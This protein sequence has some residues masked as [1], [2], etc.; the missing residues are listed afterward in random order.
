MCTLWSFCGNP[1]SP[2]SPPECWGYKHLPLCLPLHAGIFQAGYKSGFLLTV[3]IMLIDTWCRILNSGEHFCLHGYVSFSLSPRIHKCL[4][5]YYHILLVSLLLMVVAHPGPCKPWASAIVLRMPS[6]LAI[7]ESDSA[8][9][10][11][12]NLAFSPNP[13]EQCFCRRQ[14][15]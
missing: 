1:G 10:T 4:P 7:L 14:S 3:L 15:P 5:I 8:R 6:Y 2:F 9:F 12:M 11:C 13:F